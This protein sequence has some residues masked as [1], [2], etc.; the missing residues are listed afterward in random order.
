MKNEDWKECSFKDLYL[1]PSKNGVSKPSRIRGS[2]YKMINMGELFSND[3]IYDIPMELVPLTELEKQ[4]S[5]VEKGDLLFARQSLVAEGAGKCSIV[6]D[7]SPLTVFESHL[8]RVRLNPL[9]ADSLFFYYYFKSPKSPIKRIIQHCVQA[10]IKASDLAEL[11]VKIPSLAKQKE[12]AK[13]LS[14]LDDKIELNNAI[15]RNLE[16]QAQALFKNWFVDFAPFGG[17]MPEDWQI[18]KL[19]DI[20]EY[21][22]QKINISELTEETYYSTENM[23]PNRG[24]ICR[25]A[26]LPSIDQTTKCFPGETIISNIRPYFKKIFYCTEEIAGCSTDVLCFKPKKNTLEAY[27]YLLL[28]SDNFFDYMIKGSKGTKMPRGDKSQIM[29]YEVNIP[30]EN[31]LQKFE[32]IA[33]PILQQIKA[34]QHENR[35]LAVVRDEL[36]PKLMLGALDIA[37]VRI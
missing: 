25:A 12:I 37:D 24:G 19:S 23:L 11:I 29:N 20:A 36:L 22:K 30:S 16:E 35:H 31:M 34:N 21:E 26:N 18:G 15:N 2:G 8:I 32:T 5:K 14:A 6:M 4:S 3:R 28:C 1:I 27:N 13:I 17:K 10:G 7:V 33:S 9:K